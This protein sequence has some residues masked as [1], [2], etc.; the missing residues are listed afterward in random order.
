M[1]EDDDE[2]YATEDEEPETEKGRYHEAMMGHHIDSNNALPFT[3]GQKTYHEAHELAIDAH[4]LARDAH[5]TGDKNA[6]LIS[7]MAD[8]LSYHLGVRGKDKGKGPSVRGTINDAVKAA[9][10]TTSSTNSE[11]WGRGAKQSPEKKDKWGKGHGTY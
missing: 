3:P 11:G 8:K 2:H 9:E 5:E 7:R 4:G 1:K 6:D 10:D